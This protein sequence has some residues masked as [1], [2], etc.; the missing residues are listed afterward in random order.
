MAVRLVDPPDVVD[1][2]IPNLEVEDSRKAAAFLAPLAAAAI[3]YGGHL[4]RAR[5][6]RVGFEPTLTGT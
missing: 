4:Q 5:M 6:R 2:A 3:A 1:V